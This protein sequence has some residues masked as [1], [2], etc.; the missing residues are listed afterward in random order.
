MAIN[1]NLRD[2]LSQGQRSIK[3]L[4]PNY[5]NVDERSVKDWVLFAQ[6]YAK[7]LRF[8]D[9]NNKETGDWSPF[10]PDSTVTDIN[11]YLDDKASFFQDEAKIQKLARPSLVL[12]LA[13]L[14]LLE[15]AD[16]KLNTFTNRHLNFYYDQA[17]KLAPNKPEPDQ[18][19]VLLKLDT[20]AQPYLLKANTQ[21]AAGQD[22]AG[23]DRIYTTDKDL[24]VTPTEI[25][26][27]KTFHIDKNLLGVKEA[28]IAKV[29]EA[30][31]GFMAMM[32]F[33][34]GHPKQNDALPTLPN[35]LKDLDALLAGLPA[36]EDSTN[37]LSN[38]VT[39]QL[40]LSHKEFA[41]IMGIKTKELDSSQ[42]VT[43]AEWLQVYQSLE[44]AY[45]KKAIQLRQE[46]LKQK[47]EASGFDA[48]MKLALGDPNPDD[49]LPALPG[50]AAT[51][52]AVATQLNSS[53]INTQA[54]A[55]KYVNTKLLMQKDDFLTVIQTKSKAI[56]SA[57]EW[58]AVYAI[59][60]KAER[61]K[62]QW[63]ADVPQVEEW[64]SIY[65]A[66]DATKNYSSQAGEQQS[67]DHWSTF[68]KAKDL[69]SNT[70]VAKT[71][72]GLALRS[73]LLEL[74]EGKRKI[75]LT[76]ALQAKSITGIDLASLFT[77]PINTSPS[78]FAKKL[79]F[80][81]Q[82]STQKGWIEPKIKAVSYG[83]KIADNRTEP[84]SAN[85]SG[86]KVTKS[87]GSNF[88]SA[89][90]GA[91]LVWNNG[92]VYKIK[93][94][95][96]ANEVNV[97]V[98]G[99]LPA[100]AGITKY[101]PQSIYNNALQFTLELDEKVD[102]IEALA[103][104]PI[105]SFQSSNLPVFKVI[106]KDAVD[107]DKQTSMGITYQKLKGAQIA[108]TH[109]K[110]EVSDIRQYTISNDES[111]L[112]P[113]KP[114]EILGSEPEL[115]SNFYFTHPELV[116]KRLD[117]ISCNVTW[118]GAPSSLNN[119]YANYWRILQNNPNLAASSYTIKHN[120]DFKVKW[121][122]YDNYTFLAL[123]E[124]TLFNS[125]NAKTTHPLGLNNIPGSIQ[126]SSPGY[127][128]KSD[129]NATYDASDVLEG[130]RYFKCELSGA[131]FQ[132]EVYSD[133]LTQQALSSNSTINA[134]PVKQPYTPKV[135]TMT[136]SY[137][138]SL[139][140]DL[141]QAAVPHNPD[142][143]FHIHPF[144]YKCTASNNSSL[145]P[146]YTAE[147]ELYLGLSK[148]QPPEKL[149]LL[150]QMAEGSM[151]PN[152]LNPTVSWSYLKDD[153][154]QSLDSKVLSDSTKGLVNTGIIEI[155][156]PKEAN[157]KHK[158]M[159]T[160]LHW[161]K[162]AVNKN[163]LGVCNTIAIYPQ[164]ITATFKDQNND[165]GHYASPL[166]ADSIT[167]SV[168]RI[169]E[170]DS[171]QQPYTSSRG[172]PLEQKSAFYQRVSER[173]RHKNRALDA[174]DY[175]RLVLERF[176]DVYK[177]KCLYNTI[178][179]A[180]DVPAS[181]EV[182]VIPNIRG[183]LPFDP[184]Q[185]KLPASQL[186]E[187]KDYLLTRT[188]PWVQ[189]SV[190]S[191]F[192]VSVKAR[193]AVRFNTGYNTGYYQNKLQEDLK[194]YLSPWAYDETATIPMGNKVHANMLVNFLEEQVYV[195]YVSRIK[196]FQSDDAVSYTDVTALH[197]QTEYVAFSTR[198]DAVL[199]SADR[200]EVDLI[201]EDSDQPQSFIGIGY[202]RVGLDNKV[203]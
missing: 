19:N 130:S 141:T 172:K 14:E 131:D 118:M 88:T 115:E 60:E 63:P 43:T 127:S 85:L 147:G 36:I 42:T 30:D 16:K 166:P 40:F 27:L 149:S 84:Y 47:R 50:G 190:K 105:G 187:I 12:Y 177:V 151:D 112:D 140:I 196:L 89:D 59:V 110:V 119:H 55:V 44:T 73:P 179:K 18:V 99:Q 94:I 80:V 96:N 195:D 70:A 100:Q 197:G 174:W 90:V 56:V 35:G 45:A 167:E 156:M 136:L 26:Q 107:G 160:G 182:I 24:I 37:A 124:S 67:H 33:A 13:F 185:P 28:R 154:W 57:T 22:Q 114:F 93:S 78:D 202:M 153:T 181:V 111:N 180:S 31:N 193:F 175:E 201:T 168:E 116:S 83:T 138:A 148:H 76:L 122:L 77:F 161:I 109:L 29:S 91:F 159:P 137:T 145:L 49:A 7:Q 176:P 74:K 72:L 150:F 52:D 108:Q 11:E 102:P 194:R 66:S 184:F 134:L 123:G 129:I 133:V 152:V 62:R 71:S 4:D 9:T 54:A 65:V 135:K 104:E 200:H 6:K 170:L 163:S 32:R 203:G 5:F 3:A 198:A 139:E 117:S 79:P 113:K 95:I 173:L 46:T 144:G 21:L 87:S 120:N 101:L 41:Y 171:I 165:P 186:Q 126:A 191:P 2:G 98:Y 81:F 192:Y 86:T 25:T 103:T 17:L 162:A 75:T 199:V 82:L 58:T 68:G 178:A 169:V 121:T 34:L 38:Y 158:L 157:T 8:Y 183:R 64:G 48:M 155:E 10:L 125:S 20:E 142:E 92:K 143:L 106:L 51:L 69:N 146:P 164:A 39:G 97:E 53:D 23:N 128:Y 15:S 188:N 1:L 132:H 61:Q 189:L